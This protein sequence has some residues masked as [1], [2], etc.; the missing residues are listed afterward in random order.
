[1][2]TIASIVLLLAVAL[3]LVAAGAGCSKTDETESAPSPSASPSSGAPS[4]PAPSTG[5]AE[6]D[7]G[8][9]AATAAPATP[10][11]AAPAQTD[12]QQEKKTMAKQYSAPP[13]MKIDPSKTYTATIDT[14]AGTMTAEL[15]PKIAPQTVN[16]FVFLAR[17]GFYDGVIFHRVIPG[18][19][20]QGGD[21]T[22][23]GTGGPGY[24]LKQEFNDTKH[25]KGILSMA[26]TA[27]P[28]SAGSQ[29][30]VMHGRSPHLDNQY[31]AFGK[32]T[33]GL[34]VIDKIA[35]A[36]TGAQDRPRDPTKI[37]KITVEEK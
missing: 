23:T 1:M 6:T 29:F 10:S 32:V 33:Q 7:S 5:A 4:S 25:D 24:R 3:A 14:T 21:P 30:F 35:N 2:K 22:G 15:W 36:P 26:R 19:M 28:N 37:N 11:G 12:T 8:S 34:D 18:F 16:S 13:P 31:T 17:E 27:D 20:I 9:G